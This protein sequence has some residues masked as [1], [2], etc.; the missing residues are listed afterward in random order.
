MFW[1]LQALL[2]KP[3][4]TYGTDPLPTGA[5]NA[6]LAENVKISP[7]KGQDVK[8][9]YERPFFSADGTIPAGLHMTI[10]FEVELKGSGTAGTAPAFDPL[11]LACKMAKVTVGGSSVTYNP[12][13][14]VQ[15]SCTIYFNNDGILYSM[16]GC[17]GTWK[18]TLNAQ[19]I[20]RL[21][22]EMTGLFT[23]PSAAALPTPVYGTQLTQ[24][25]QVATTANTPVFTIGGVALTL[26]QATFDAGCNVKPRFWVGSESIIIDGADEMFDCTVET[27]PLATFNPYALAANATPTPIILTHGTGA[28]KVA[29][30]TQPGAQL[31][32]SEGL[33]ETDGITEYSVKATPLPV[34][35]NDQYTLAFT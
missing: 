5:A 31:M 10:T 8:R 26:K 32:R 33:G 28:G 20:V 7:M 24:L 17:R 4:V 13:S 35:A 11:L 1:R 19:G 23:Q 21:M 25:P 34:V 30:L 18:Y 29:T 15:G 3:E 2:C 27:P 22:F 6:I 12:H 9:N 14:G 16:R